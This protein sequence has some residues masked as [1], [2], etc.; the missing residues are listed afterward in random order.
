MPVP[1]R[2]I[3]CGPPDAL[4]RTETAPVK[5]P[6]V[7]GLNVT[8]IMQLA[9]GLTCLPQFDVTP[10]GPVIPPPSSPECPDLYL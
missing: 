8:L 1:E 9:P 7:V 2:E 3:F 5:G 6:M 10:N 4:S